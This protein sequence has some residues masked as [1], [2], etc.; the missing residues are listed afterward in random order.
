MFKKDKLLYL[1]P[2]LIVSMLLLIMFYFQGLYPFGSKTIIQVDADYQYVPT[3]YKIWDIFHN[4]HNMFFDFLV[5]N[6]IY[7]SLIIQGG[8]YSPITLLVNLVSRSNIIKFFNILVII[9]MSLL[10]LTSYIY[11]KNTFKV[12]SIYHIIFSICYTFSGWVLLNYFNIMWLDDVIL[13][14]L[15]V[16]FL[17]KLLKE[18]KYIGYFITLTLSLIF[19]YYISVF[20]LLFIL[21]YSFI[22]IKLYISNTKSKKT[23]I[24]LGIT[25]LLSILISSFSIGPAIMQTFNSSRLDGISN[26]YLFNNTINK[27]LYLMFNS[28]LIIYFIKL[29]SKIKSKDKNIYF[30]VIM[31]ILLFIGVI[32]EPINIM[33]HLG[34]YWSFP[35]RYS[36]LTLF[37]MAS[38]GLYYIEKYITNNKFDI[39]SLI[40]SISS[41]ILLGIGIYAVVIYNKEIISAQITLDFDDIEV[42]KKIL[43][44]TLL[45]C[46]STLLC[47]QISYNKLK[48]IIMI[49]ISI[50]E[51]TSYTYLCMHYESGYFLTNNT[52]KLYDNIKLE[53]N[54]L[55]RY[56][57]DYPYVS[58]DYS[59]ILG[60]PT[61]DNWLHIIPS[62]QIEVYKHM[63]YY[64]SGTL[65]R[66]NGGTIFTDNLLN[67]NNI[68]TNEDLDED[69]ILINTS[70]NGY[71]NYQYKN[72]LPYGLVIDNKESDYTFNNIFEYNNYLYKYLF[73]KNDNLI[74]SM[75]IDNIE[76]EINDNNITISFKYNIAY[77][78]YVYLDKSVISGKVD[79]IYVDGNYLSIP[80]SKAGLIYL[81]NL[82]SGKHNITI[83]LEETNYIDSISIGSINRDK[84]IEFVNT[85]QNNINVSYSNNKL[86]INVLNNEDNKILFLPINNIKGYQVIKNNKVVNSKTCLDNFMCI[87]LDNGNN[88]IVVKY[89]DPYIKIFS[90][91]SLIGIVLTIVFKIYDK[92]IINNNTLGNIALFIYLITAMFIML[93][94]YLGSIIILYL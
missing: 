83:T 32:L 92:V 74:D 71:N 16:L 85:Y 82:T 43:V 57:I 48:Y 41:I 35:Y 28:I 15:I 72:T 18:G 63:G 81:G 20:I 22:Y 93:F 62:S 91:I 38:G 73:N 2:P 78:G 68:I 61:I 75:T 24:T 12:K 64:T 9:K 3:L 1:L 80:E 69:Y 39:S 33:F 40:Y 37:I 13:F 5:G 6:N 70:T 25:T 31:F 79:N 87:D 58:P 84:Y 26:T 60:V 30:Y 49:I 50:I 4:N 76:K 42:F 36:F 56:K 88:D 10:S 94:I 7:T 47:S 34:S 55:T 46:S 86:N 23:A 67:I 29:I 27:L 66:S 53:N 21:I 65:I 51:I 45:F 89:H 90:I 19:S 77:Q 17:D 52:Q 11:F 59:F 54:N 14:P 8:I 44:I